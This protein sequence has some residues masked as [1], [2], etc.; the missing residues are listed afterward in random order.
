MPELDHNGTRRQGD[1]LDPE[2]GKPRLLSEKCPTC[3]F[4]PGN[5]MHLAPGRL[6]ELIEH[7]LAVGAGL[8]CHQ[9]LSYS[10]TGALN[11][12]CR[13]FYE[14]YGDRVLAIRVARVLL[15]GVTEVDPPAS[16]KGG[17]T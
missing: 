12:W 2:T 1:V 17:H 10:G 15:G 14:A 13:G 16:T 3:V 11:A 6:Q 8:T 5:P 7:N 9:T 4:R